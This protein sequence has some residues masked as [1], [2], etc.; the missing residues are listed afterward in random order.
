MQVLIE[1]IYYF[2]SSFFFHLIKLLNT[3][4]T[5]KSYLKRKFISKF[6]AESSQLI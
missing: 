3:F 5:D 1:K 6:G 2:F 4:A